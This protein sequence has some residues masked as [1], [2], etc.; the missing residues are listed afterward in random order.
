MSAGDKPTF[1]GGL[2]SKL[3]PHVKKAHDVLKPKVQSMISKAQPYVSSAVA[4]AKEKVKA[5]FGETCR[6]LS[7]SQL[8]SES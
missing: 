3:G 2:V 4:K 1:L 7:L 8:P 6:L 5:S